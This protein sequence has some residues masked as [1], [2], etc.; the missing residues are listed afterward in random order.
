MQ[1]ARRRANGDHLLAAEKG[2]LHDG[3]MLKRVPPSFARA[4]WPERVDASPKASTE[5]L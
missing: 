2:V 3:G 4:D 1:I 5:T